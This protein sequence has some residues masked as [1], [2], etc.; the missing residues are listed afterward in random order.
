MFD[1]V[2][3]SHESAA[4]GS[5]SGLVIDVTDM[6]IVVSIALQ[7]LHREIEAHYFVVKPSQDE[8][9]VC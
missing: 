3:L 4:A 2:S 9:R 6:S 7:N 1:Y 8:K 5:S